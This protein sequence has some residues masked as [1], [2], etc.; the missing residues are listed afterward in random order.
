MSTRQADLSLTYAIATFATRPRED[1]DSDRHADAVAIAIL[2]TVGVAVAGGGSDAARIVTDWATSLPS[3]GDSPVWGKGIYVSAPDAALVNGTAAHALDWDDASPSMPMHPSAVLVPALLAQASWGGMSGAALTRAYTAGAAIFRAV[4]EAL[5]VDTSVDLG[6]H[7]TATSGRIAAAAAL[8]NLTSADADTTAHAL[9]LVAST[10]SGSVSNFG[11]MTK[12]LHAGLA[13]RD[14]L[15]AVSL[16]RGGFTANSTQLEHPHGFFAMYGQVDVDRL[17]EIPARLEYWQENWPEDWSI[18]RYPCCY[19]THHAAD[20]ALDIRS[21]FHPDEVMRIDVSIYGPDLTILTKHKPAT[22]LEAKFSLEYVVAVALIRG[23]VTMADFE[24]DTVLDPST[25]T[26]MDRIH[27]TG[28]PVAT[29]R[30]ADVRVALRDGRV[31][32]TRTDVTRGASR[33]PMTQ[34][35]I[36]E[37][38]AGACRSAGWS[39]QAAHRVADEL[40]SVTG[41][42]T[43]VQQLLSVLGEPHS[44]VV[45]KNAPK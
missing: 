9:G 27:V 39:E 34:S 22:G 38:F 2:D 21:A 33:N 5:P 26:L 42:S 14:A 11:T 41:R 4:S 25:S 19:G 10:A 28:D 20:A 8:A 36:R 1:S 24:T 3:I 23:A 15:M 31:L 17:A 29:T 7:N 44:R 30:F 18:K 45:S 16:A 43:S 35:E 12:P 6:W 40:L 13:A 32:S 37:K